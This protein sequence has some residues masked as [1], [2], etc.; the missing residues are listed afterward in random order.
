MKNIEI[1]T[2]VLKHEGDNV[3]VSP[4]TPVRIFAAL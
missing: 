3:L 1:F 2:F 4:F